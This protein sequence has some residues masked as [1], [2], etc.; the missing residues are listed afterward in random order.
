MYVWDHVCG[1]TQRRASAQA[2]SEWAGDTTLAD[3]IVWAAFTAGEQ[4]LCRR[5]RGFD[6]LCHLW[7]GRKVER[8]CSLLL[9]QQR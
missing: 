8:L 6:Q 4:V 3:K 1:L 5:C 2:A 9:Q 7:P